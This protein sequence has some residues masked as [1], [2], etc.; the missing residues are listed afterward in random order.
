MIYGPIESVCTAERYMRGVPGVLQRGVTSPAET[1]DIYEHHGGSLQY[2][3]YLSAPKLTNPVY[4]HGRVI[5]EFE[6][7]SI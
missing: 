5:N 3:T 6:S 4:G 2:S 1:M 7:I